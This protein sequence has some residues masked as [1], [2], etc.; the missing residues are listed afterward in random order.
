VVMRNLAERS[1]EMM[2]GAAIPVMVVLALLLSRMSALGVE[3]PT[4]P[5]LRLEAGMHT[6]VIRGISVDAAAHLLLTVS[7]DKTARLWSP[8]DGHLIRVLRPPIGTGHEGHLEAGALSP[9]GRIAAVG[10]WTG[11]DWDGA[12]VS[13]FSMQAPAD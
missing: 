13:I 2:A 12:G 1:K 10:G 8:D 3:P 5:F 9:D 11:W 6:A 7:Y 4:E